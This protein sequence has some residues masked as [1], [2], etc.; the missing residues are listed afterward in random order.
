MLV[1]IKRDLFPWRFENVMAAELQ[2]MPRA[3]V[4]VV[5]NGTAVERIDLSRRPTIAGLPIITKALVQMHGDTQAQRHTL[6]QARAT[7]GLIKQVVTPDVVTP[8]GC[9]GAGSGSA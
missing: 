4:L 9:D 5:N 2:Q 1:E 3:D 8:A 7:P 6:E